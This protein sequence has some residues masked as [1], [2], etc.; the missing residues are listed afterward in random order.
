MKYSKGF[1]LIEL[2]TAVFLGSLI[3]AAGISLYAASQ[4]LYINQEAIAS[5]QYIADRGLNFIAGNVRK[6]TISQ[7]HVSH[8]N[9]TIGSGIILGAGN[10]ANNLTIANHYITNG[11]SGASFVN[12]A[13][14]QLVIKYIPTKINTYDC[15]GSVI[16]D[17][18]RVIVERYFVRT[19]DD[20][21]SLVLACDAGRFST[22]GVLNDMG[23]TGVELIPNVVYFHVML[24]VQAVSGAAITMRDM[25]IAQYKAD[26]TKPRIV[27]VQLGIINHANQSVS[28]D[29]ATNINTAVQILNEKVTL[30]ASI[31]GIANQKLFDSTVRTIAI[32]N[33][34]G[35]I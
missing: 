22:A 35:G 13:S 14:D 5:N 33:G 2:M 25:T 12:K 3:T 23:G 7:S 4:K 32:R 10:Y 20:G 18:T 9:T 34:S 19:S 26:A 30:N 11:E 21:K 6:A 24:N 17:L 1:T 15:E 31:K 16:P 29:E 27:G 28:F 8:T